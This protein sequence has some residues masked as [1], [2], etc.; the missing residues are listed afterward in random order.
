ME[1]KFKALRALATVY[2]VIAW[3]ALVLGILSAIATLLMGILG[4]NAMAYWY[5]MYGDV[6]A[7][8][9]GGALF[10]II[11]FLISL[12]GA[13]LSFLIF[14]A[15]SEFIL[16]QLAIEENT[17]ETAYYL[18]GEGSLPGQADGGLPLNR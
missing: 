2:K 8:V 4:G 16:L 15:I 18:R 1:K 14:F 5:R 9:P 10:G 12:L 3:I 13:G 11:G 7:F 17:R 6:P